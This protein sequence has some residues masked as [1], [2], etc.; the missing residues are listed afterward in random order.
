MIRCGIAL[1]LAG[2]LCAGAADGIGL[3]VLGRVLQG[4]GSGLDIVALYVVVG[5]RYPDA[6]RPRMFAAFSAAWV[7]PGLL[8]PALGG[9]VVDLFGWRM[10]FLGLVP[11]VLLAGVA[12][13]RGLRG[14]APT[15][16]ATAVTAAAAPLH[17][18]VLAAAGVMA[19]HLGRQWRGTGALLAFAAAL[20]LLGFT[21]PRL[22]PPGT[23]RARRGLPTVA[24]LRGL[25]GAAFFGTEVFLP[26]TLAR[27]RGLSPAFAGLA[28]T[29]GARGW[30]AGSWYQGHVATQAPERR[31]RRGL[32]LLAAGIAFS[33]LVLLPALPAAVAMI[34]WTLAGF[35]M[36]MAYATLS[37][38]TLARSDASDRGRKAPRCSS[39]MRCA[40]AR[41][42]RCRA[43]C[44]PSC[45]PRSRSWATCSASP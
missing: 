24:L 27:E 16:A 22:L 5:M 26:L 40:R 41:R 25:A 33:A 13:T 39:P 1:L 35:G 17:W 19:L 34:G 3:L 6:L 2:L 15:S 28:L 44:S 42:R 9:L 31:L 36:G 10:V 29:V 20:G 23:L 32:T 14:S 43:A 11:G 18:A 8:G 12:V 4:L 45:T 37:V 30:F 7:L 21:V 38:L